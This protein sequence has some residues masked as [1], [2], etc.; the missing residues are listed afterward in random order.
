[1]ERES[2][3]GCD[4]GSRFWVS[5]RER[6]EERESGESAVRERRMRRGVEEESHGGDS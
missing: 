4:V 5:E 6:R 3:E 2:E 1:M